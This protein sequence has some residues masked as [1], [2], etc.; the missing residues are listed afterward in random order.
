MRNLPYH[1]PEDESTHAA[2][3]SAGSR[4]HADYV[5]LD[6]EA[7][8][9]PLRR[10][11]N[12]SATHKEPRLLTPSSASV[13]GALA[14]RSCEEAGEPIAIRRAPS[15]GDRL[16]FSDDCS[17][18]LLMETDDC[19]VEMAKVRFVHCFV[20]G[21]FSLERPEIWHQISLPESFSPRDWSVSVFF[22]AA[23][24][25]RVACLTS[26]TDLPGPTDSNP[27]PPF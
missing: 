17:R 9:G 3:V 6:I 16:W 11:E 25:R 22:G 14:A 24:N 2:G 27:Y 4:C 1:Q 18:G 10:L 12:L 26:T 19:S 5:N 21:F 13:N 23:S 8:M 20:R 7:S 15:D